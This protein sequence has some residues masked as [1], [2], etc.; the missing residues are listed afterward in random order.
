M[1]KNQ[2]HELL[3][4]LSDE[5]QRICV[6][7]HLRFFMIGGTMLG[8]IRHHGFIPWDDDMDFGMLRA[9]YERFIAV[10]DRELDSSMFT[11]HTMENEKYYPH[12]YAKLCLIGTRFNEAGVM[13][14]DFRQEIFIDIFPFDAAPDNQERRDYYYRNFRYLQYFLN[15]KCRFGSV[16]ARKSLHY[17][18]ARV[19]TSVVSM[20]KLKEN[21]NILMRNF[22]AE[23]SQNSEY[24]VPFGGA[25]GLT[26][27]T[28][29]RAWITELRTYSFEDRTFPG[30]ACYESY[31][32]HLYG[33]YRVLPPVRQRRRHDVISV[34]CGSYPRMLSQTSYD[35]TPD[36]G[37]MIKSKQ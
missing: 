1:Q 29:P 10:C 34:D 24:I 15:V 25:Y 33:D 2:I 3:L 26:R 37:G 28:I 36:N 4:L 32:T 9:D 18:T 16:K 20:E 6:K 7:Y 30:P 8:A 22:A 21:L 23:A 17:R 11:L 19:M 31:L 13:G 35:H 27:E 12:P 5:L 14:T